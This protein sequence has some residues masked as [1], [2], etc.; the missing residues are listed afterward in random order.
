MQAFI[1]SHHGLEH[2]HRADLLAT[3]RKLAAWL[4]RHGF[5]ADAQAADVQ[6]PIRLREG[7]RA[8]AARRADAATLQAINDASVGARGEYRISPAGPTFTATGEAPL[9]RAIATILAA[10]TAAILTGSWS[11]LK[12]CPGEDCGWA[13]YDHSRNQSGRWCS[14]RVCG[15][16]SKAR[17]HYWPPTRCWGSS[18]CCSHSPRRRPRLAAAAAGRSRH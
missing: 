13:F 8:L 15:G 14:M 17:A 6:R 4:T 3:P 1:N 10:V 16:R 12:I 18:W 9:D 11:H 5:A 2:D 7:L